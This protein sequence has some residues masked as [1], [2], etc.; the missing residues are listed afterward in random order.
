MLEDLDVLIV[1]AGPAGS[2][3]AVDLARRGVSTR[4]IDKSPHGFPGSRAKGIQPRSLEVFEDLGALDD[5][6]A[7][8]SPYPP[9]GI[10][11]GPVRIPK[12][13][14]KPAPESDATPYRDTWL[15]PQF[16]TD[17]IIQKQLAP[18]GVQVE[19]GTELLGVEQ[20]DSGVTARIAGPS[21]PEELRARYVV[22][23]DGGASLVRKSV[24]IAFEGQTNE[25]DRMIILDC[26]IEGL[27][28]NHWHVWPGLGG[29]FA[30]ACPLPH[31][32]LFQVMIRLQPGEAPDLSDAALNE[33]F[34]KQT[35]S[36]KLR[37][38]DI[39]WKTVFRPNIRLAARYREGR[40][41]LAGD[42]AHVH[43]PMGAQGLNTGIQDAYNLGWK[44]GQVLAGAP[45]T[46]LE[47][48]EAERQPIAARVLGL[49]TA[50]Y[51][52]LNRLDPASIK[53]GADEKQ[54]GIT[55][56]G[57]PLASSEA[58]ATTTLQSGDR[59]PDAKLA[60]QDRTPLRL[61]DATRGPAFTLF[62]IGQE[63]RAELAAVTWPENGAG[64]TR[65]AIDGTAGE[66]LS[67]SDPQGSFRSIYG[68]AA[69]TLILI[70][71]DGY[72]GEIATHDRIAAINN[73]ASLVAPI[74]A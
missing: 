47:S 49:S 10:H 22:G 3:L 27:G 2:T 45:E 28:R 33:R 14:S 70:R 72:I 19:Y 39:Q 12:R 18:F 62:A 17:S 13:M 29:R 21:G 51:E 50:K 6:L 61:F 71:P 46:L 66:A 64:L 40:V 38:S 9:L 35:H 11:L 24:G 54:L 25:A 56:K 20:D 16:S 30:G 60:D 57:G 67:L 69:D 34:R 37:L 26:R 15:I 63:A 58:E 42:A 44:L 5:I 31:G 43:T 74:T 23:A 8:G 48:Y 73:F 7:A 41:F 68:I 55:Y 1:G 36:G 59:A 32:D 65:V 4:I 52:A 53:R